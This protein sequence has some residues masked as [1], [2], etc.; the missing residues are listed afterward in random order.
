MGQIH[1]TGPNVIRFP[2]VGGGHN[3][4][5]TKPRYDFFYDPRLAQFGITE[6]DLTTKMNEANR[7]LDDLS[8]SMFRVGIFIF[9]FVFVVPNVLR[10]I[11][12]QDGCSDGECP[13]TIEIISIVI[14]M[15]P[16]FFICGLISYFM[17]IRGQISKA[18]DDTFQDWGARG[19]TVRR[20]P[21]TK[22]AQGALYLVLPMQQPAQPP[23]GGVQMVPMGGAMGMHQGAD[24]QPIAMARPMQLVTVV[25]PPGASAGQMLQMTV[26]GRMVQVQIPHGLQE[27]NQFQMQV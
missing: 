22:H 17:K 2:Q 16:V 6:H 5:C 9:F 14:Q 3:C 8:P 7:V 26:N 18:I 21:K 19:I 13:E 15:L 4:D 1:P 25:V 27:G 24:V 20:V 23:M 12:R 10:Q 11:I